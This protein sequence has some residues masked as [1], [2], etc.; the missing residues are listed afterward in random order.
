MY[1]KTLADGFFVF[2][3]FAIF[4]AMVGFLVGDIWLASTQWML[5]AIFAVL[6]G[7]YVKLST[8]EDEEILKIEKKS[9]VTNKERV[10]KRKTAVKKRKT[11][12]KAK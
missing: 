10:K 5:V 3:F 7:I 4:L 6:V 12:V 1:H 11:A 2:S 9:P 8:Q